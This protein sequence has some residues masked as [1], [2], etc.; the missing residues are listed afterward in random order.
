MRFDFEEAREQRQYIINVVCTSCARARSYQLY[1][2]LVY[3]LA[4][5]VSFDRSA[6][7]KVFGQYEV[8]CVFRMFS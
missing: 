2:I 3:C 6:I 4:S 5:F 7:E 1:C 8:G